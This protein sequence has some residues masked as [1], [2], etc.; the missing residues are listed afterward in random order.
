MALI[1]LD[2]IL[3]EEIECELFHHYEISSLSDIDKFLVI[4]VSKTN[5]TIKAYSFPEKLDLVRVFD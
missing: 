2:I 3:T 1:P 5:E 4:L